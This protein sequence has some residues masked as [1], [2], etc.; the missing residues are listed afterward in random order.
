M[1]PP[2]VIEQPDGYNDDSDTSWDDGDNLSNDD[3]WDDGDWSDDGSATSD[4]SAD[5]G[6]LFEE[7]D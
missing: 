4:D 5:A 3:S 1:P 6:P 7:L 2:S